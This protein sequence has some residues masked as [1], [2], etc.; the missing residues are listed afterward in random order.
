VLK[1]LIPRHKVVTFKA[2][3]IMKKSVATTQSD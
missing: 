3:P 2:S 1:S